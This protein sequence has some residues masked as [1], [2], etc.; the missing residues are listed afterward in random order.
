MLKCL[1]ICIGVGA[2]TDH[3][4]SFPVLQA[5]RP[6]GHSL[7]WSRDNNAY[8]TE[9]HVWQGLFQRLIASIILICTSILKN[10]RP[11]GSPLQSSLAR[12]TVGIRLS[13]P[14]LALHHRC[15]T[16]NINYQTFLS[17]ILTIIYDSCNSYFLFRFFLFSLIITPIG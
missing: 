2:S 15:V 4:Q 17:A 10:G 16:N 12:G 13:S 6:K 5:G 14:R 8:S 9:Q 7:P 3:Y 1:Y 11:S